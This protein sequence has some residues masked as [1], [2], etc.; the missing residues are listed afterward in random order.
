MKDVFDARLDHDGAGR[1][2]IRFVGEL[3]IA[4]GARAAQVLA[5]ARASQPSS[6][7]LDLRE[8]RYMDS[9]GVELIIEAFAWAQ[10]EERRLALCHRGGMVA[11]VLE[12]FGLTDLL[13]QVAGPDELGQEPT[14]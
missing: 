10:V 11:R 12:V 6:V 1:C 2:V 4:G 7:L 8:L 5:A 9:T 3:D 14:D 13:E